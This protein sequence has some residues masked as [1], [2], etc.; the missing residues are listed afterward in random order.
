[1]SPELARDALEAAP[2]AMVII[3]DGGTIRFANRQTVVMFGRAY[4]EIIGLS[5]DLL[6]TDYHLSDG[7]TGTQAILALRAAL[8]RPL[9]AVLIT[10][11]TSSAVKELPRDPLL[12][13]ASKPI[14]ADELLAMFRA[15]MDS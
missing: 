6:V 2:D 3:D 13:F 15:L 8:A 5:I 10:G 7:E 14:E 11:D 4:E 1:M 12:R 9:K